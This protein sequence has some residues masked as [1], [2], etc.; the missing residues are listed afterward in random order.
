MLQRLR[1]RRRRADVSAMLAAARRY[2]QERRRS[3]VVIASIGASLALAAVLV[4]KWD[5]LER[6]VTGAPLAVVV[7]AVVLQI[8]ALI[9]RSEAWYS[10]VRASGGS[11]SRRRLYRASGMGGIGSQLN[12]Q[13]GTAARIAVL[14]RSAPQE[15]PAVPTLIAA[16]LPILVVEASLAAI[17]S[18]TLV[19]PLGLPWWVPILCIAAVGAV[20][21][22]LRSQAVAKIRWLGQ[23]LAVTR[24]LAGRTRLVA[25]VLI[26]VLAQVARNWLLLHAVGV[27]ASVFDAI[28]V[29]IAVVSLGQLPFGLSVGAAASVLIL[30]PQGVTAAAAA[31]VLLTATGTVGSLCFAAWAG[32]DLL[33]GDRRA[34]A[35]VRR[36][37]SWSPSLRPTVGG[38]WVALGALPAQRRL[39]IERSY[40]GG[41]SHVQITRVLGVTGAA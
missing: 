3:L 7:L 13:L 34:Q 41:L 25:F 28:A 5:E 31:G 21:A 4:A 1:G 40:F 14:R 11:V 30:G 19:G 17:V 33:L 10:C 8:V 24:T 15:S 35:V 20:S 36:V 9:S 16:E 12:T 2:C 26:A 6:G 38:P 37:R 29:L 23:G 27:D 32:L 39:S 18:F 22:G